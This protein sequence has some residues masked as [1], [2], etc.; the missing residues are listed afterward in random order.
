ML[1]ISYNMQ[2]KTF[3]FISYIHKKALSIL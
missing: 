1:K 3:V 2:M